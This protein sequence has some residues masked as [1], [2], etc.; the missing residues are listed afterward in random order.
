M[1]RPGSERA[2]FLRPTGLNAFTHAPASIF[3]TSSTKIS[4]PSAPIEAGNIFSRFL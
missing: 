1:P 4:A 3:P 2:V